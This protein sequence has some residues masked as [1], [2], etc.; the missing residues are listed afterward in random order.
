MIYKAWLVVALGVVILWTL[1]AWT[2]IY[3]TLEM[4]P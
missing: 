4:V 1:A 3:L 2:I